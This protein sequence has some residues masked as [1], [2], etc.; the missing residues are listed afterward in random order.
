MLKLFRRPWISAAAAAVLFLAGGCTSFHD[1]VHNGF[2]VG[3]NYCTPPAPVAKDW[4]DLADLRQDANPQTVCHWW[5]VFQDPILDR[6]VDCA[7]HQNLTLKEAGFRILQARA[8]LGIATGSIFPQT[9]DAFGSYE[10]ARAPGSPFTDQWSLGFGLAWELDFWG[11]FR[12]AVTSADANLEASVAGYDAAMV[13][14]IGDVAQNYV[15]I[16][17][18]QERIRLLQ[19]NVELQ[20]GI[21]D[22]LTKRL[23]Q[24]FRQTPLDTDQALST[25]RQTEA[26]IPQLEI[27]KRQAENRLCILMGI[28]PTDLEKMLGSGPIPTAPPEVA[29]GI[30]ADLLRRRP[31]VRQAER[32][33]A[34]QAEQIGIADAAF[35][36]SL[37]INGTLGYSASNF[38][39]LFNSSALN[40]SV[41]P[42]FQWNLLNYGRILNNVRLQDGKLQEL[43]VTYQLAVLQANA[44]V[45]NGIIT[46]LRAQR[47]SRLADESVDAAVRASNQVI[48]QLQA[49]SVDYSRYALI[50]QNLVT[51]QDAMAQARGQIAQ[52]LVAVYRA[53]GGGWELRME[54]AQQA[55]A[56][57]VPPQP[58]ALPTPESVPAPPGQIQE[59]PKT[60]NTAQPQV[61]VPPPNRP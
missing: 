48:L 33:A 36:P 46:F 51:Y 23:N 56:N 35:Y 40:G 9:Q 28:P 32:L 6:M 11:K 52:G 27:D 43:I 47:V 25:L 4:I 34:A 49:G 1:Y 50:A 31:D 54:N 37:T 14:M 20:Q 2:K 26:G 39:E 45:E 24:G 5:K 22:F 41:G 59:L 55:P 57:P 21:L 18:D 30:P 16:R 44:D 7:Y 10:R 61:P 15:E 38:G 19:K 42:S 12:R 3:P 53:L 13:T 29:V 60:N 58:G 8:S 17:T